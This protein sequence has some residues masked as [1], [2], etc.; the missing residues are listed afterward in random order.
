ML[1]LVGVGFFEKPW[2]C[3]DDADCSD[4]HYP[5][6]VPGDLYVEPGT[7]MVI[8]VSCVLLLICHH[9]TERMYIG[10]EFWHGRK[11]LIRPIW[12]KSVVVAM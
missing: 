8:E 9:F 1:I 7:G 5:T 6:F 11:D 2:W 4:A 10:T 12:L 3:I